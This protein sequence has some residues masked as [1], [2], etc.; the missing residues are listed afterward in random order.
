M[1]RTEL[2]VEVSTSRQTSPPQDSP[3]AGSP[4]PA[5]LSKRALRATKEQNAFKQEREILE[6]HSVLRG[7]ILLAVLI[8]LFAVLHGGASRGFP[9]GWWRQW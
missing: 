1:D 8:L 7:L 9:S 5:P 3:R 6:R 4:V 2:R